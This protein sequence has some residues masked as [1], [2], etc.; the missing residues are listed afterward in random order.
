MPT[1]FAY[2]SNMDEEHMKTRCSRAR[3]LG[4]GVL[5]NYK[6]AFTR[7]SSKW[8]SSVA[9]VVASQ[10]EVVWGVLYELSEED[11]LKLDR[12]EGHPRMYVRKTLTI[13]KTSKF[14][15][16]NYDDLDASKDY[17]PLEAEVYEVLSKKTI[18]LSY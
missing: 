12:F 4:R 9:D 6:I 17:T 1:Y 16:T 5:T 8:D 11:L 13:H 15:H 7:Y 2:G 18:R 14:G 10:G 3:Y